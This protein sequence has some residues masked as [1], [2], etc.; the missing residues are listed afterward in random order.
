M[1]SLRLQPVFSNLT[2]NG[3]SR[4]EVGEFWKLLTK[5]KD[6][7][8]GGRRLENLLWRLWFEESNRKLKDN[9]KLYGLMEV[10]C[11]QEGEVNYF[12]ETKR[13]KNQE[14]VTTQEATPALFPKDNVM[15]QTTIVECKETLKM[16]SIS[17]LKIQPPSS[18]NKDDSLLDFNS[19]TEPEMFN[20]SNIN[21]NQGNKNDNIMLKL[22]PSPSP[23]SKPKKMNES[24]S[25]F[26]DPTNNNVHLKTAR[27]DLKF[28]KSKQSKAH[29]KGSSSPKQRFIGFQVQPSI[30]NT[31]LVDDPI[32]HPPE[33]IIQIKSE[34][35][36]LLKPD[37]NSSEMFTKV[38]NSFQQ[39]SN[40]SSDQ[41]TNHSNLSN[42]LKSN[43]RNMGMMSNQTFPFQLM[44][45]ADS[46][47]LNPYFGQPIESES[48]RKGLIL[49]HR[50]LTRCTLGFDPPSSPQQPSAW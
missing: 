44:L 45:G 41:A 16:S 12:D 11:K 26:F 37:L 38:F 40:S 25:Q 3:L 7:A 43:R 46:S 15:T 8:H 5:V 9:S 1:S 17:A 50:P 48:L 39:D 27:P 47:K 29:S 14:K 2:K 22:T 35:D 19:F 13:M 32:G 42:L 20:H 34:D 31:K 24:F 28:Q 30:V 33:P 18:S 36:D 4:E 6:S 49:D 21:I 10:T 23:K